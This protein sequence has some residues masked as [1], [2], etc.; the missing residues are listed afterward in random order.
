MLNTYYFSTYL[1]FNPQSITIDFE[2][3]IH[4]PVLSM[5]SIIIVRCRFHL[6]QSW[7]GKIQELALTSEY[8]KNN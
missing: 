5:S 4:Q 1:L 7:Y 2:I 6:T 3:S 8:Q